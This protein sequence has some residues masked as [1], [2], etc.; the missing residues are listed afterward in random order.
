MT[1]HFFLPHPYKNRRL[2]CNVAFFTQF[3][4]KWYHIDQDRKPLQMRHVK[5]GFETPIYSPPL[6]DVYTRLRAREQLCTIARGS[7]ANSDPFSLTTIS[8]INILPV[9]LTFEGLSNLLRIVARRVVN[10]SPLRYFSQ[11]KVRPVLYK[12]TRTGGRKACHFVMN[13]Y[14]FIYMFY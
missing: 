12:A 14:F 2:A 1:Q 9:G 10:L 3:T 5:L 6:H 8:Y 11:A 4:L 7:S 13:F